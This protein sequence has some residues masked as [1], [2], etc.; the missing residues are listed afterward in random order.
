MNERADLARRRSF[1]ARAPGAA[2]LGGLALGEPAGRP[3]ALPE[4]RRR[5]REALEP[6]A[7]RRVLELGCAVGGELA[8]LVEGGARAVGLELT[9]ARLAGAAAVAPGAAFLVGDAENLPLPDAGFDRVVGNSVLLH[10]ERRRAFAELER[11]LVSGGRA[12]FLEP[13]DAH[14]LLRVYRS[15]F[16]RRRGMVDYPAPSELAAPQSLE[17]VELSCWYLTAALPVHVA[18]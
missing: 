17:L 12:V 5:W 2:R 10:L 4:L 1:F 14:P 16:A 15:L 7:G 3:L 18:R 9:A 11:V 8:Y 6:L 13:L